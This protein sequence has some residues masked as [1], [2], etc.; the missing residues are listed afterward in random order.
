MFLSHPLLLEFW[1]R[2]PGLVNIS[3]NMMQEGY[4]LGYTPESKHETQTLEG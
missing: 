4:K 2:G 1:N 3:F